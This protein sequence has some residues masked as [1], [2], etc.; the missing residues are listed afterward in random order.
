[1]GERVARAISKQAWAQLA[2]AAGRCAIVCEWYRQ[3]CM[4][5]SSSHAQPI[6]RQHMKC[7]YTHA[8]VRRDVRKSWVTF[9][10]AR[11]DTS[12]STQSHPPPR[13][14][15]ITD[16]HCHHPLAPAYTLTTPTNRLFL[17]AQSCP[18]PRAQLHHASLTIA[19]SGRPATCKGWQSPGIS[20]PTRPRT[21]VSDVG[22]TRI[23]VS[24]SPF[25]QIG[26]LAVRPVCCPP[27]T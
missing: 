23:I 24:N 13:H 22:S 21:P 7:R 26:L 5:K 2:R 8:R 6:T 17:E 18:L 10:F 9:C 14:V 27:V 1:V 25:C 19:S 20:L 12:A 3:R 11:S 16:S 15:P 4:N